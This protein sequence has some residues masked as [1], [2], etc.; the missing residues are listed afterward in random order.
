MFYEILYSFPPWPANDFKEL[1]NNI[2]TQPLTFPS[3]IKISELTKDFIRS[4]LEI[5]E[6]ERISWD[7][8]FKHPIFKNQGAIEFKN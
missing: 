8:V 4:C 2:Y 3:N 7:Q 1:I 6:A 5:N